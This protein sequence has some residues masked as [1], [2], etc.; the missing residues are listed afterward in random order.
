MDEEVTAL[1]VRYGKVTL[2]YLGHGLESV[3][4]FDAP[5]YDWWEVQIAN[6]PACAAPTLAK[7]VHLAREWTAGG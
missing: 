2:R 7:A 4:E 5:R 6:R 1:A 3:S